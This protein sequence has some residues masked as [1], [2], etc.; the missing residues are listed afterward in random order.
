MDV[1]VDGHGYRMVSLWMNAALHNGMSVSYVCWHKKRHRQ[2]SNQELWMAF[3]RK[4]ETRHSPIR[5]ML[6]NNVRFHYTFVAT[7]FVYMNARTK[8]IAIASVF[9][10]LLCVKTLRE[11]KSCTYWRFGNNYASVA[12][13]FGEISAETKR[14]VSVNIR[15]IFLFVKTLRKSKFLRCRRLKDSYEAFDCMQTFIKSEQNGPKII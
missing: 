3:R 12:A 15:N 2:P 11:S 9:D 13:I 14:V 7:I 4:K 1:T 8:L 6:K 5:N 10:P